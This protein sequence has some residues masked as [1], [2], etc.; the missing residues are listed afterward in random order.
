MGLETFMRNNTPPQQNNSGAPPLAF[1][2]SQTRVKIRRIP[3]LKRD[4]YQGETVLIDDVDASLEGL[5]SH[6]LDFGDF[7]IPVYYERPLKDIEPEDE[8]QADDEMGMM[9]L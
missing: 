5:L 1:Q 9:I 6:T 7:E 4:E 8:K 3:V 2:Q